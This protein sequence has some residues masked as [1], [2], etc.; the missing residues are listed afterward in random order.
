MVHVL[1]IS[2]RTRRSM[3]SR[4]GSVGGENRTSK[5]R[6][7]ALLDSIWSTASMP[8]YI[9]LADSATPLFAADT[10]LSRQRKLL[11]VS[12]AWTAHA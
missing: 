8:V 5:S 6:R 11:L 1:S 9:L 10:V 3:V 12:L 2:L 4:S 7:A